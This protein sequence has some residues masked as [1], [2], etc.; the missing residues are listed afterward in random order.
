MQH[1]NVVVI[2]GKMTTGVKFWVVASNV[3]RV[4]QASWQRRLLERY[5]NTMCLMDAT[6]KTM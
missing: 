4:H 5:G 6:C 3:H 2:L 1:I